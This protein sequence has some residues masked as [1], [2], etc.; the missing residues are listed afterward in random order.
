MGGFG[1]PLGNR[2]TDDQITSL[3]FESV[4]HGMYKGF[5]WVYSALETVYMYDYRVV[6]Y[7]LLEDCH[8]DSINLFFLT[9]WVV[10]LNTSGAQLL[11]SVL[12]DNHITDQ[13]TQFALTDEWSRSFLTGKDASLFA[14]FHP[15][16]TFF[17]IQLKNNFL[18]NFL[19]ETN[20]AALQQIDYQNLLSPVALFSQFL[21][22]ANI[23]FLFVAFYFSFYSTPSKEEVTVDSDYLS[24][25]MSIESEK[26]IG[27]LDDIIMP[28]IIITFVFG[29]YFYINSWT[30]SAVSEVAIAFFFFPL[31]YFTTV[32]TPTFLLYD[33]GILYN[34][35]LRGVV[36]SSSILNEL[37]FD[38]IAVI[39]FY[40]RILTQGVRL[41][42]MFFTYAAM[43]DFVLYLYWDNKLWCG[44][45]SFWEDLAKVKCT[46]GSI[47]YFI[48][49]VLPGHIINWIYEVYHTFFVVTG[50]IVAYFAMIYWLFLFLF[51]F[52]IIEKHEKYF[53]ER[54]LFRKNLLEE[55][56]KL[57]KI[58]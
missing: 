48:I 41:A 45:M 10:A 30:T 7:W 55:I 25:S 32:N 14:V 13:I 28:A 29:W 40:V 57:K 37:L 35:Y 36:P 49:F 3:G 1:S 5:D 22:L 16:I 11:W 24:A 39:A 54:R 26:E 53:E 18:T 15:E 47:D 38:Y 56:K 33:F 8:N 34:S 31:L 6:V 21:F 46:W 58:E 2:N 12:L 44:D 4:T 51:T 27:S 50:Q 20:V 23:Y 9:T 17:K 19:T 43:H 52:F 42:L